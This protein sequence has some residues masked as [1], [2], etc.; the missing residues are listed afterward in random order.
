MAV[1]FFAEGNS[2]LPYDW[3]DPYSWTPNQVPEPGDLAILQS[4]YISAEYTGIVGETIWMDFM[5]GQEDML[6]LIGSSLGPTSYLLSN[7]Q[8]GLVQVRLNNSALQG[9]IFAAQGPTEFSIDRYS[10]AVNYG[11][12]GIATASGRASITLAADGQFANNGEI[13][14]GINGEFSLVFGQGYPEFNGQQYFFN[15][16]KLQADPGGMLALDS[17]SAGTVV[18]LNQI[19]ANGGAVYVD[20]NMIMAGPGALNITNGGAA[21]LAGT[22]DGG[23]INI[24]SGMLDFHNQASLTF[25]STLEFSG[26]GATLVFDG[27]S[28]SE[29]FDAAKNSLDISVNYPGQQP[30]MAA[31]QLDQS[32]AYAAANFSVQNG[33]QIVY[34]AHSTGS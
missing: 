28:V 17:M 30:Y 21:L 26:S 9:N 31:L 8:G 2:S 13:E 32:H 18:N 1:E 12:I 22:T 6:Y 33:N 23:T 29:S 15:S 25:L 10:S 34:L 24:Q 14:A 7:A 3:F 20:S 27:A 19:N 5:S 4:G 11:W 16:G